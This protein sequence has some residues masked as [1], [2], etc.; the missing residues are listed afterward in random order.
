[1]APMSG[2][3]PPD[4]HWVVVLIAAWITGGLAGL[5]W[6]FRQASF[7]KKID[8]SSKAVMMLVVTTLIMVLELIVVVMMMASVSSM[9][10]RSAASTVA[11][12][13]SF[14]MLLSLAG[15]VVAL[16]AFFGMRKSLVYYYN[17]VE[18]IGLRLS[19]VMTFFFNILYFQYHLSRIA[20]W[21]KTGRLDR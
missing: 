2:P 6:A 3:V 16:I 21:K 7:I 18:N 1:M 12:L 4:M 9:R 17:N 20:R 8:Q 5:I 14:S 13:S 10:S 15:F 19:G 11:S